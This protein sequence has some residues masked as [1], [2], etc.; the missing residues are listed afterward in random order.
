MAHH[1]VS[2][3]SDDFEAFLSAVKTPKTKTVRYRY[4]SGSLSDFIVKSDDD[5]NSS[6]KFSSVSSSNPESATEELDR[7][8]VKNS[9]NLLNYDLHAS[10]KDRFKTTGEVISK[11]KGNDSIDQITA[12]TKETILSDTKFTSSDKEL[13]ENSC[14]VADH[15]LK[16]KDLNQPFTENTKKTKL[17]SRNTDYLTPSKLLK[18]PT[19]SVT[20]PI[21]RVVFSSDSE[22]DV[23]QTSQ[24][25]PTVP[26]TP[27]Q[28]SDSEN[29]SDFKLCVEKPKMVLLSSSESDSENT[30]PPSLFDRINKPNIK[31]KSGTIQDASDDT[32]G[33]LPLIERIGKT[34]P[35]VIKSG[36]VESSNGRIPHPRGDS[37]GSYRTP[38]KKH[39]VKH[40]QTEKI[41]RSRMHCSVKGCF[42]TSLDLRDPKHAGKGFQRSKL[43]LTG[44]LFKLFNSSIFDDQLPESMEV[45]WAKRLTKT[46]GI[47]KCRRITKTVKN[48]SG[49][50]IISRQYEAS[51]SLSDKVIDSACRLR[52]TLVHEM[53]HAAVWLVNNAN[54]SHGPFWKSWAAKARRIHPE[55]PLIERC[56]NY[57]IQYKYTYQCT[58][59]KTEIGRHSKSLDT[60]KK[61]CG[62]CHGKLELNNSKRQ[63]GTPAKPRRANPFANFV[64]DNY[65]ETRS[66]I[67]SNGLPVAHRDIMKSLSEQFKTVSLS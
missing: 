6:F 38:D 18:H 42:L 53:C 10:N 20:T 46:A 14:F 55:L 11:S 37:F 36:L 41:N 49:D 62:L 59:C 63:N 40:A 66:R 52:D 3:D 22:D 50:G 25:R 8:S 31:L 29:E 9:E 4:S 51:I 67:A 57:D 44:K 2:S 45:T 19:K 48:S 54:E 34:K 26:K 7:F 15:V 64:K 58:R 1:D 61:V 16:T 32:D 39:Y 27:L 12:K 33:C 47:T 5:E 23:F 13:R 24:S 56:H 65:K 35:N 17:K 21:R 30:K 28:F 60:S 43:E